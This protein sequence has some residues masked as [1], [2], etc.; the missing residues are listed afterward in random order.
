M[1]Q[2]AGEEMTVGSRFNRKKELIQTFQSSPQVVLLPWRPAGGARTCQ[3]GLNLD[4]ALTHRATPA[5]RWPLPTPVGG[6]SRWAW[7]AGVKVAP[8]GTNRASTPGSP[9]TGTGSGS[10]P[11]FKDLW[12]L[13]SR[14][15]LVAFWSSVLNW[16]FI[17]HFPHFIF[18]SFYVYIFF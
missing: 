12:K 4:S 13:V 1:S 5:G 9:S 14:F 11:E 17:C 2:S 10:R 15:S 7:S 16:T 6:S 3:L 18:Y 8:S